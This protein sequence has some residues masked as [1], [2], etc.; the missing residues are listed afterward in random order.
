MVSSTTTTLPKNLLIGVLRSRLTDYN[1]TNRTGSQWIYPGWTRGDL[2]K[3]SYPRINVLD[4][5]GTG[6][7]I[8]IARNMENHIRMQIDVRVWGDDKDPMVLN[9]T[10]SNPH[11]GSKLADLIMQDIQ[12]EL[13][14]HKDD[15]NTTAKVL[16]DMRFSGPIDLGPEEVPVKGRTVPIIRKTI[17]VEFTYL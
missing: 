11:E 1:S 14:S 2:G 12:T 7:I 13:N 15:F 5:G 6:E 4:V 3:N 9:D 17:D 16:H 8:D 10:N